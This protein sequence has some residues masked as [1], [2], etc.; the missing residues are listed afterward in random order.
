MK[1]YRWGLPRKNKPAAATPLISEPNEWSSEINVPQVSAPSL[2]QPGPPINHP[3]FP[4]DTASAEFKIIRESD[5]DRADARMI[6]L[7]YA[8]RCREC[9]VGLSIGEEARW[10]GQGILYGINCHNDV[11]AEEK[12]PK[13][14]Y[15]SITRIPFP[16]GYM[17]T[18]A[19]E[20][21]YRIRYTTPPPERRRLSQT[22]Y[23]SMEDAETILRNHQLETGGDMPPNPFVC[24]HCA[25]TFGSAQGRARHT[26]LSH[27]IGTDEA[28]KI[29]ALWQE[30]WTLQD[31]ADEMARGVQK[32]ARVVELRDK[33]QGDSAAPRSTLARQ[34]NKGI[35]SVVA[36]DSDPQP[37]D[38]SPPRCPI[39]DVPYEL[40]TNPA[41]GQTKYVHRYIF[42][43]FEGD[44]QEH[45]RWCIKAD[46]A[47]ED[48]PMPGY[49]DKSNEPNADTP[50]STMRQFVAA[51]ENRILELRAEV[52]NLRTELG[53]ANSEL[54]HLRTKNVEPDLRAVTDSSL[55]AGG[56]P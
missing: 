37:V 25:R 35:R 51:F 55:L 31:L 44:D 48:K 39:H 4:N 22:V 36:V 26:G 9:G 53:W 18:Q 24:L 29:L 38:E 7:Q 8:G 54:R 52:D 45:T 21:C 10:Y 34:R 56:T 49:L 30:G 14:A 33:A 23:G 32:I 40:R 13:R 5:L 46:S 11:V 15:G 6:N 28:K 41:S 42:K 20:Q 16:W 12:R 43:R 19:G 50:E 17:P 27:P 3:S 1:K 47:K 2:H